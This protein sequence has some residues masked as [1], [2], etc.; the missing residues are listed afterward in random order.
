MQWSRQTMW[1]LKLNISFNITNNELTNVM[2]RYLTDQTINQAYPVVQDSPL[3]GHIEKTA[4]IKRNTNVKCIVFQKNIV[5]GIIKLHQ[6]CLFSS[7]D[8]WINVYWIPSLNNP[9]II[10]FNQLWQSHKSFL[11]LISHE[12]DVI[13]Y[14]LVGSVKINT[15]EQVF[16]KCKIGWEKAL[17][18]IVGENILHYPEK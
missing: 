4:N 6:W 11:S 5:K 16:F 8:D 2:T 15:D 9:H 10:A 1:N 17:H 18:K 13:F 7:I 3:S 12:P 14:I